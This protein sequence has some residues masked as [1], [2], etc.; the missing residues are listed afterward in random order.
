MNEATLNSML[1]AARVI[2]VCGRANY[3]QKL[4]AEL[5]KMGNSEMWR[6]GAAVRSLRPREKAKANLATAAGV[7]GRGKN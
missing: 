6:A 2:K 4:D 1:P 3:K 7:K 5:A